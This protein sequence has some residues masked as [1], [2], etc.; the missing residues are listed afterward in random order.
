MS[1]TNDNDLEQ[2]SSELLTSEDLDFLRKSALRAKSNG[3]SRKEF[4]KLCGTDEAREYAN[5][6]WKSL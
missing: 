1:K 6:I 4:L 2:F 3:L 5:Y